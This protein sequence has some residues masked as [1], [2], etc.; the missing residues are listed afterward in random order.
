MIILETMY[1]MR[2]VD[3]V[4]IKNMNHQFLIILFFSLRNAY[5]AVLRTIFICHS[6]I[7]T[8]F[9]KNKSQS[10][11]IFVFFKLKCSNKKLHILMTWCN[12]RNGLTFSM[13]HVFFIKYFVDAAH[14]NIA[15]KCRKCDEL[16]TRSQK[17]VEK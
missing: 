14:R 5:F 7:H 12:N 4:S 16:R 6:T 11:L 10:I 1:D 9:F 8:F 3:T 2:V 15:I 13:S 17:F